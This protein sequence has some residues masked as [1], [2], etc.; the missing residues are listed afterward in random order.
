MTD[1]I[2]SPSYPPQLRLGLRAEARNTKP[3]TFV[4]LR[5]PSG[6]HF[7]LLLFSPV[8]LIYFSL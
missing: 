1:V 8:L 2:I 5:S 7:F 6:G 3:F 4:S